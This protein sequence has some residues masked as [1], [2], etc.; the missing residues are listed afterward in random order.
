[1]QSVIG[2]SVMAFIDLPLH[3]RKHNLHKHTHMRSRHRSIHPHFFQNYSV[4][5]VDW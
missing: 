1:M 4:S 3:R 2:Q 5:V